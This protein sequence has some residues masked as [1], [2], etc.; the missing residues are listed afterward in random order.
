MKSRNIRKTPRLTPPT[1]RVKIF[2]D[3]YNKNIIDGIPHSPLELETHEAINNLCRVLQLVD[4][5]SCGV[6]NRVRPIYDVVHADKM[7][8]EEL[9]NFDI[10]AV[11]IAS[12]PDDFEM[13]QKLRDEVAR[14][15]FWQKRVDALLKSCEEEYNKNAKR[16]DKTRAC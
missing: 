1:S 6:M 15:N 4:A 14:F 9:M 11:K 16:T 13:L 7:T 5:W 2:H 10:M 8:T 3:R 12:S